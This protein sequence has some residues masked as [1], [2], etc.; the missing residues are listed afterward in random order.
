MHICMHLFHSF[1]FTREFSLIS[2]LVFVFRKMFLSQLIIRNKI[3]FHG[4]WFGFAFSFSRASFV[5]WQQMENVA[6]Y[7]KCS[8]WK[9]ERIRNEQLPFHLKL[10]FFHC[11]TQVASADQIYI[12]KKQF[13]KYDCW[14][15]VEQMKT[16]HLNFAKK[17]RNILFS[18]RLF[19][20]IISDKFA[21]FL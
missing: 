10:H 1:S 14:I 12:E 4:K 3:V 21:R 20:M 5:Q 6:E 11:W 13:Q 16:D 19:T 17:L 9:K 8:A 18:A 15:Q 2:F 7:L